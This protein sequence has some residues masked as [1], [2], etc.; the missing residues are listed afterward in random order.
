MREEWD[1]E[2]RLLDNL[3][4]EEW[5]AFVFDHAVSKDDRWYRHNEWKWRGSRE[6]FL[7]N[8][9]RLFSEPE[10]LLEAY[11]HECLN[12][13]FWYL[14][15]FD[16]LSEWLWDK[17]VAWVPRQECVLSMFPLYQRLFATNPLGNA[18]YMWWDLFCYFGDK[19]RTRMK[20]L[21]VDV[22]ASILEIPS[23]DCQAAA[24]HG[25]G[26]ID[27]PRKRRVVAAFIA[28]HPESDEDMLAYATKSLNGTVL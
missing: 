21:M 14:G 22:L 25:L 10:F 19:P 27:T 4:F 18:C 16:V 7:E 8:C 26:H 24:L 1:D 12:Q 28:S 3:S 6:R 17:S 13:G 23:L 5:V 11:S 20:L 9:A 2:V 15:S